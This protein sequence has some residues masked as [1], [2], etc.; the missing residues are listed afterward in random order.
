MGRIA[1]SYFLE[2]GVVPRH[3]LPEVMAYIEAVAQRWRLPIGNFFHAGDGN[4]HPTILFDRRDEDALARARSAANEILEKCI[5][6][7][8]TVSGEH[9][10]GTEKQDYMA[11]LYTADDLDAMW[12]VKRSFDPQGRLNPGKIFPRTYRPPA[13]RSANDT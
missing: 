12:D 13:P 5:A 9:G 7:G 6:V 1:P 11:L 8:G 4:I 10:I 3:K 2:D